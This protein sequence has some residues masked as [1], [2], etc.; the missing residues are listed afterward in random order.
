MLPI[1]QALCA[2]LEFEIIESSDLKM[3]I[4]TT[5][6]STTQGKHMYAQLCD[7]QIQLRELVSFQQCSLPHVAP[8]SL[9]G[10]SLPLPTLSVPLYILCA[11]AL[12]C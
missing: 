8:L 9:L 1:F 5:L 4:I 10:I 7:R 3:Q 11:F 6:Q 2:I 12:N